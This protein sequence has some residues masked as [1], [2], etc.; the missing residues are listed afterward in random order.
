MTV[1]EWTQWGS[2]LTRDATLLVVRALQ[3]QG[4]RVR[5]VNDGDVN[6]VYVEA[7]P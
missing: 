6:H 2:V 7:V 1:S 5:V 3:A 4:H